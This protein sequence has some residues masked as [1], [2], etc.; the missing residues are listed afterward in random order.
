MNLLSSKFLS[1]YLLTILIVFIPF[2]N[3]FSLIDDNINQFLNYTSL[4]ICLCIFFLNR[5]K[6]ISKE[7]LIFLLIT[8][9]FLIINYLFTDYASFKWLI[10]WLG[11]LVILTS[12]Y[13]IFFNFNYEKLN[14]LNKFV[15]KNLFILII[16]FSILNIY[17]IIQ[18]YNLILNF[19]KNGDFNQIISLYMFDYGLY[20]QKFGFF[21]IIFLLFPFIFKNEIKKVSYFFLLLSLLLFLPIFIGIRSLLLG[22]S[23]FCILFFYSKT[24]SH[25]RF[26]IFL[27][28]LLV[29][30][31]FFAFIDYKIFLTNLYEFSEP[32]SNLFLASLYILDLNILGIG[33]GGF[34]NFVNENQFFLLNNFGSEKMIAQK[35][36]P[37]SPESDLIFFISS[38]GILSLFFFY[39]I[40]RI[41]IKSFNLLLNYSE[42]IT[43]VE[44]LLI[45][46]TIILF[47]MGISEDFNSLVVWWIFAGTSLGIIDRYE[48]KLIKKL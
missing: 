13:L 11:F 36:F 41:I 8:V 6:I 9:I 47:F 25:M 34:A 12:T 40:L 37:N 24:S 3:S 21:M 44:K 20:K 17:L 14:L 19:F 39:I 26:L 48:N 4:V 46:S 35:T 45:T 5:N 28:L 10:N 29:I 42:N 1:I 43:C 23:L 32:R 15:K 2:I 33:N 27:F 7:I 18:N 38:W 30:V 31:L 16:F 22:L